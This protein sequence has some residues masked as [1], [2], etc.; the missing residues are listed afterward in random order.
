MLELKK[1]LSLAKDREPARPV[2]ANDRVA[3]AK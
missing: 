3:A 2:P 1:Q